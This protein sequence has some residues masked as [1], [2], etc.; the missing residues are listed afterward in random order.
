MPTKS[1]NQEAQV[2]ARRVHSS[3]EREVLRL[4]NTF[5]RQVAENKAIHRKSIQPPLNR[6]DNAR[7]KKPVR[8]LSQHRI[9]R[10]TA[11]ALAMVA[12]IA[13]ALFGDSVPGRRRLRQRGR[14]FSLDAL[15]RLTCRLALIRAVEIAGI[16]PRRRVVRNGAPVG[17]RRR[18][19]PRAL[20]RACIGARLRKAIK[21]GDLASRLRFLTAALA[22]IDAFAR[23]YF[24]P[25]ALRRLTKLCATVPIAPP[26]AAI[27]APSAF[28]PALADSS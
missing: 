28:S 11:W 21:R 19:A 12:W 23:R 24:L 20:V 5:P 14:F 4:C 18:T 8:F 3:A 7:M 16:R 13:G 17:F 27:F 6:R 26:A 2:L 22:D 1:G 15:A 10:L 9:A 25:R